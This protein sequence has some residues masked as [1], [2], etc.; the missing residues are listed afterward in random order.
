MFN[1]HPNKSYTDYLIGCDKPGK[2]IM[3]SYFFLYSPYPICCS[4][5]NQKP[6]TCSYESRYKIVLDSDAEEFCGYKRLDAATEYFTTDD[7]W[8]GRRCRL[9]V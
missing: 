3:A 1:F 9:M 6:L 4:M 8:D 7:G 5:N 2:Y